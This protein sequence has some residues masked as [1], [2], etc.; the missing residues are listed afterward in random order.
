MLV[1]SEDDVAA[2][3]SDTAVVI[4]Q[5]AGQV[6]RMYDETTWRRQYAD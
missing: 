6:E 2:F 5:Q 4:R 1:C 3:L